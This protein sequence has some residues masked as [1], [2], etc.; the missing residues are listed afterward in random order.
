MF[1]DKLLNVA[2]PLVA[3]TVA[4]PLNVDVPG[5]APIAI[6]I[7]A[8]LDVTRLPSASCTC[9]VTA[10]VMLAP[11]VVFVG[12]CAK[13]SLLAVPAVMLNAP[14]VAPVR[15]VLAAASVYAV[16]DLSRDR[17]L[18]VATPLVAATVAV[19]LNVEPPGFVPIDIVIVA[20]LVVTTL[21]LVS[22]TC[23]VTA[24]E[25]L[26][27]AV[28]FVG[29]CAKAS[30]LAVPA[31]MLNVPLVAPVKPALAAASV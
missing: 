29:C 20:E 14:L 7:D 12:C 23:T 15:P 24:G 18:K 4:V 11:A 6:A 9:T 2:T 22:C 27:P 8:E 26:A 19:P 17:L 25:M 1:S 21:P 31:V 3:A 10:G 28:V 13:A 5:F 30:L 16:P